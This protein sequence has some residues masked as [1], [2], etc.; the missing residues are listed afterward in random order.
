MLLSNY[1]VATTCG[2][3]VSTFRFRGERARVA[4]IV[5]VCFLLQLR[6][7]KMCFASCFPILSYWLTRREAVSKL[8][9]GLEFSGIP[10]S[11]AFPNCQLTPHESFKSPTSYSTRSMRLQTCTSNPPIHPTYTFQDEHNCI[12]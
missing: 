2:W 9:Y 3:K 8:S 11:S 10:K 6:P 12:H 4:P 7:L 5:S 1:L